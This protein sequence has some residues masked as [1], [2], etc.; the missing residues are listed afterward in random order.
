MG[1]AHIA[2]DLTVGTGLGAGQEM[3]FVRVDRIGSRHRNPL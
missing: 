1:K 3:R 2:L